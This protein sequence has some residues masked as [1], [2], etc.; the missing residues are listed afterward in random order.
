MYLVINKWAIAVKVSN[1]C[2]L[3]LHNHWT[4]DI[5]VLGYI[6]IVWPKEHSPEVRSF[7]PGTPCIYIHTHTHTHIQ[8][9]CSAVFK[10]MT[11][12]GRTENVRSR[13]CVSLRPACS[14]MR[15]RLRSLLDASLAL[16]S[17]NLCSPRL[18]ARQD[19]SISSVILRSNFRIFSSGL[20]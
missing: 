17:P 16:S 2:G 1:F 15:M 7:P 10:K 4:L 9:L 18:L 19:S 3:Y 13:L 8:A 14:C 5:G 6:V 11:S 12:S 20:K